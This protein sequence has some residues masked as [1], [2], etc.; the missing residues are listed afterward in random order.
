MRN[1]T[2]EGGAGPDGRGG[3]VPRWE[4]VGT[5]YDVDRTVHHEGEQS[6]RCDSLRDS[7]NCGASCSV[8]LNQTHASPIIVVGWSKTDKVSGTPD[9]NFSI[10]VDL[11]YTDG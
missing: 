5:G 10:Y 3:G 9:S 1:G 4:P 6:I 2:F 11:E 8:E 7:G